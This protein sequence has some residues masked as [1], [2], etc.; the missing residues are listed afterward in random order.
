MKA[1][2]GGGGAACTYIYIYSIWSACGGCVEDFTRKIY[3]ENA[4]ACCRAVLLN[5]I[6]LTGWYVTEYYYFVLPERHDNFLW[7]AHVK[8]YSFV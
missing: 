5:N 7:V 6:L 4:C 2:H 8:G 1:N 3:L